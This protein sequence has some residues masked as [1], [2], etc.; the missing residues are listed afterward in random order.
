MDD[1]ILNREYGRVPD[2]FG[3][4]SRKGSTEQSLNGSCMARRSCKSVGNRGQSTPE[5]VGVAGRAWGVGGG[6]SYGVQSTSDG[7]L[8]G[9]GALSVPGQAPGRLLK[10][11]LAPL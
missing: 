8:V 1:D 7:S 6:G 2:P 3:R 10:L 9:G 11:W 4:G 5:G